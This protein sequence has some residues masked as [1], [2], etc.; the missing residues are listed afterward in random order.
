[1]KALPEALSFLILIAVQDDIVLNG[2]KNQE[3][4]CAASL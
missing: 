4:N 3:R 1:M 2:D